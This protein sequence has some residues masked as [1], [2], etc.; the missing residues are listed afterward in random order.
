VNS[1]QQAFNGFHAQMG[2]DHTLYYLLNISSV[3]RTDI[4]IPN[5]E[6]N[7]FEYALDPNGTYLILLCRAPG[8]AWAYGINHRRWL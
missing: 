8:K 7:P 4:V 5:P 2:G 3:T 1:A 6:N